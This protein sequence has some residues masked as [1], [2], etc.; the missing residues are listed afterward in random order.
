MKCNIVPC[1]YIKDIA[2]PEVKFSLSTF[3]LCDFEKDTI[4]LYRG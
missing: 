1:S 4:T 3:C 2:G